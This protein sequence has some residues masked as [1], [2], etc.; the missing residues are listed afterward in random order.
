MKLQ[1]NAPVITG[2]K[3]RLKMFWHG[4]R[5]TLLAGLIVSTLLVSGCQSGANSKVVYESKAL[6]ETEVVP[7]PVPVVDPA[8]QR[9][10]ILAD[11]LYDAS[12]AMDNNR[13][14]APPGNNAYDIYQE[15]LALDP[16]NQVAV[17]GIQNIV[18]RYIDLADAAMVVGQFDNAESYLARARRLNPELP[19]L[20]EAR[21]RLSSAR[22]TSVR[23]FELDPVALSSQGLEIM[24]DLAEIAEQ[25]RGLEATFLIN[26]RT[27][28]EGRWIYKIMREAVGGY[29]LRGNIG[30]SG[31]PNILV[32]LPKG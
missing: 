16:G 14:M 19:A 17:Q 18:L 24:N 11:R 22:E 8:F 15:V 20:A 26:A 1:E 30:V 2:G 3:S 21:Q 6:P 27:D 10:R 23:L 29:R 9:A 31:S 12:L 5:L 7:E 32:S 25:I 13:L 28:E 4:Q